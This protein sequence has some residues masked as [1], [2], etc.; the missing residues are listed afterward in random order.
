MCNIA[1]DKT[2]RERILMQE[3]SDFE[4]AKM[5]QEFD[6]EART[7]NNNATN[8]KTTRKP[9]KAAARTKRVAAVS[10]SSSSS[11]TA[12]TSDVA[13]GSKESSNGLDNGESL[14]TQRYFLR[15]RSKAVKSNSASS[16]SNANG[17]RAPPK[18][19]NASSRLKK[20][21]N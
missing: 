2:N 14:R 18:K 9:L 12:T 7:P 16:N 17:V 10:L 3:K 21:H 19:A 4:L 13:A 11:S 1:I 8:R 5:L 15:N 20:S 6:E